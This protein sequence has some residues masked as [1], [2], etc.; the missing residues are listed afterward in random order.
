MLPQSN[1]PVFVRSSGRPHP[2]GVWTIGLDRI[3]AG[4]ARTLNT[5]PPG[6]PSDWPGFRPDSFVVQSGTILH[7][8]ALSFGI[9][10]HHVE[11]YG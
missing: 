8:S 11:P 6:F 9:I 2:I 5:N 10:G 4:L 1:H 7:L 3:P